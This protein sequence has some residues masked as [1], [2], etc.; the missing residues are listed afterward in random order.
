MIEHNV[1]Q[2]FYRQTLDIVISHSPTSG[3]KEQKQNK[4]EK[5]NHNSTQCRTP[6]P[7]HNVSLRRGVSATILQ[8]YNTRQVTYGLRLSHWL[9]S[10]STTSLRSLLTH[11]H[12][13]WVML[14]VFSFPLVIPVWGDEDGLG[15]ADGW[16]I[17]YQRSQ[18]ESG[19]PQ[20][21]LCSPSRL[22]PLRALEDFSPGTGCHFHHVTWGEGGRSERQPLTSRLPGVSL[23]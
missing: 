7:L 10:I 19:A 17:G 23:F 4:E 15:A 13:E 12:C 22:L 5:Q 20:Q 11:V 18:S 9:E 8:D 14:P 3:Q 21:P 6:S 1:K 16:R 2:F